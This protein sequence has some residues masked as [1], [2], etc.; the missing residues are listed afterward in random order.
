MIQIVRLSLL[1]ALL[2][3][4]Q[5]KTDAQ[6]T[7]SCAVPPPPGAES[8]ATTCVYCDFNGYTGTNS[9]TP[10]G[11]NTV[12]GE[13]F[14]HNDQW[15]GFVAGTSCL[16]INIATSNC[17]NGNGLQA[18][19][20]SSCSEDAIVCNPGSGAGEGLPLELSYC[21]FE[22]GNTYYLMVDG[23]SGDV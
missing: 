5:K 12:C 21:G 22:P 19:F 7:P 15:F 6:I 11:G 18:A 20:F 17:N 2:L 16:T 4:F 9:G 8:C 10:S 13:I 23:W 1:F 3:A 14:L